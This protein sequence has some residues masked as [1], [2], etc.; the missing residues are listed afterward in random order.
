MMTT[1]RFVMKLTIKIITF[2]IISIAVFT[3][4][5]HP[6]INNELAI[7]QMENSNETYI[8]MES[9]HRFKNIVSIIYACVYGLFAGTVMYDLYK[10][11]KTK[12]KGEE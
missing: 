11:V 9:Y 1:K 2:L 5:N 8:F 7:G 4:L 12:N 3:I 10:F 6:I